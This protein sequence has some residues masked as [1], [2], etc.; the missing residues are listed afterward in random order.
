MGFKA[1]SVLLLFIS[2]TTLTEAK[3]KASSLT[4]FPALDPKYALD[5]ILVPTGNEITYVN[6]GKTVVI[7]GQAIEDARRIAV[8][9]MHRDVK[10]KALVIAV[11]SETLPAQNAEGI[12]ASLK[13]FEYELIGVIEKPFTLGDEAELVSQLKKIYSA[14]LIIW[15]GGSQT[16]AMEY[17]ASSPYLVQALRSGYAEGRYVNSGSSAGGAMQASTMIL[18]G[19]SDGSTPIQMGKRMGAGYLPENIRIDTHYFARN[20]D[21]R[22]VPYMTKNHGLIAFGLDED[23]GSIRVNGMNEIESV[24]TKEIRIIDSWNRDQNHNPRIFKLFPGDRM[25]LKTRQIKIALKN[26]PVFGPEKCRILME[27]SWPKLLMRAK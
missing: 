5:Q 1:L 10:P 3:P 15:S 26:S 17:Y 12:I 6:G 4:H 9:K 14:D 22:L 20:R 21:G 23:G 16:R 24:G 18:S 27:G 13:P 11:P 2:F 19:P 7:Y 25:N 8:K